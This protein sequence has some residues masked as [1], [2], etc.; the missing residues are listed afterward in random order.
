MLR[1]KMSIKCHVI[2]LNRASPV[3]V[4]VSNPKVS[5]GL[6]IPRILYIVINRQEPTSYSVG[7]NVRQEAAYS[8]N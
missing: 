7:G 5:K 6:H 1:S 3:A 4:T 8:T 2:V